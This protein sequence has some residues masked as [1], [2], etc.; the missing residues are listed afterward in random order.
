VIGI[1]K[2]GAYLAFRSLLRGVIVP[3]HVRRYNRRY[4]REHGQEAE[5]STVN[6]NSPFGI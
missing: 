6:T 5:S 4:F 3:W 2:L 1:L